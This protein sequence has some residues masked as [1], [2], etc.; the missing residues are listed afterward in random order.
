MLRESHFQ[1]SGSTHRPAGA[2]GV[3]GDAQGRHGGSGL[4]SRGP[5]ANP[6]FETWTS[7]VSTM[8]RLGEHLGALAG[9]HD[10]I[11]RFRSPGIHAPVAASDAHDKEETE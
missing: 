4:S 2:D 8:T 3:P 11:G 9:G 7:A 6:W 1:C 5:V 10:E